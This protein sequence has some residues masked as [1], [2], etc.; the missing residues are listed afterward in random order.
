MLQTSPLR[1]DQVDAAFP[2]MQSALP[3]LTLDEWRRYTAALDGKAADGAAARGIMV[4]TAPNG[5]LRA[6]FSYAVERRERGGQALI[7]LNLVASHVAL[8]VL[9]QELAIDSLAQGMRSLAQAHDC[10]SIVVM[11]PPEATQEIDYFRSHGCTVTVSA[12]SD[13]L[14][15]L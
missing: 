12:A 1:Q 2:L 9:G 4:A 8:P 13:T 3:G 5:V 14:T 11:L 7:V 15:P 10:T 6:A